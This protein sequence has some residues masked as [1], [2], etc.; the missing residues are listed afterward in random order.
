M[1]VPGPHGWRERARPW[2]EQRAWP[3]WRRSARARS[4]VGEGGRG[5]GTACARTSPRAARASKRGE[6]VQSS[7]AARKR[8]VISCASHSSW[9]N[10]GLLDFF[11]LVGTLEEGKP[12]AKG[13]I[14]EGGARGHTAGQEGRSAESCTQVNGHEVRGGGRG[15]EEK[16]GEGGQATRS[17][18]LEGVHETQAASDFGGVRSRGR[19]TEG[20]HRRGREEEEEEAQRGGGASRRACTR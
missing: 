8:D 16:G 14:L 10:A 17:A 13:V 2:Q 5:A 15:G 4:R 18:S 1:R 20:A 7:S 6:R 12:V 19:Q 9:E 11:L 3:P